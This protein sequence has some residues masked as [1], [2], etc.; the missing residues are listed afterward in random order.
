MTDIR[1]STEIDRMFGG[2]GRMSETQ[3]RN[4]QIQ[5][6]AAFDFSVR[7]LGSRERAAQYIERMQAYLDRAD[8]FRHTTMFYVEG[9]RP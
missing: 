2:F 6:E 9:R 5:M 3:R 4:W 7:I 1:V 8:G